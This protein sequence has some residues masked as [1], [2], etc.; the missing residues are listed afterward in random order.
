MIVATAAGGI[1]FA[2]FGGQPLTILGGT[3]PIV[4]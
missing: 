2:L 3:G 4:I 1:V